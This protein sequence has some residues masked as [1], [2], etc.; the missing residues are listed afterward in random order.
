MRRLI[1]IDPGVAGGLAILERTPGRGE[2][3]A[4]RLVRTP[5]ADVSRNGRRLR[6][7][8]VAGMRTALTAALGMRGLAG[9]LVALE[10]QQAMPAVL[11]GRAQGG[12]STFRTGLGYGLWLGLV[13]GLGLPYVVVRPAAWKRHHGLL[14]ADKRASRLRA[15]ERFPT[16]GAL[17]PADEGPAEALLLA[18]YVA[19]T[20]VPPTRKV[21][22]G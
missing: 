18:A 13:V 20:E 15:S 16:L 19:A 11:R 4:A 14:G 12:V 6:E 5:V 1:G 21:A 8:D 9:V 2:W 17:G 7:Y 3:G 10:H 22:D